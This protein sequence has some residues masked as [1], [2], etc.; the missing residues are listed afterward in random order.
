MFGATATL[1]Y[2]SFKPFWNDLLS[3]EIPPEQIQ[4]TMIDSPEASSEAAVE[5]PGHVSEAATCGE[6][7]AA[8]KRCVAQNR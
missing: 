5:N 8:D 7:R 3:G 1:V 2:S 6:S 4:G